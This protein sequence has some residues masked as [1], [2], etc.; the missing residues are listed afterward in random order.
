MADLFAAFLLAELLCSGLR[1]LV[2][3][4]HKRRGALGRIRLQNVEGDVNCLLNSQLFLVGWLIQT[5][6]EQYKMGGKTRSSHKTPYTT[7]RHGC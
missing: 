1:R 4:M 5:K 6:N 2:D 3:H 7:H